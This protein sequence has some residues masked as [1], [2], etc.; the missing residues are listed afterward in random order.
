MADIQ[1]KTANLLN[2]DQSTQGDG[3]VDNVCLFDNN[4][5]TPSTSFFITEYIPL[6]AGTYYY[7]NDLLRSSRCY[8]NF[9]DIN[10]TYLG[11]APQKR[12]MEQ[13]S[14]NLSSFT[15]PANTVYIRMTIDKQSTQNCLYTSQLP[16]Y[17][18]YWQHSLRKLTS[19]GWQDASVKE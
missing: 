12:V 5:I 16:A 15:A 11:A 1:R 13:E 6:I 7:F 14:Y 19:N 8:I 18:P 9:Y 2:S 3:Y 10:K 17:E 4:E